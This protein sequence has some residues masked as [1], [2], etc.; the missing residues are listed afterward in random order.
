MA[1]EEPAGHWLIIVQWGT[2]GRAHV[3]DL[4]KHGVV[5]AADDAG[6]GVGPAVVTDPGGG[7]WERAG[8][9]VLDPEANGELRIALITAAAHCPRR[10]C[11]SRTS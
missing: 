11:P 8:A 9:L 2:A 4:C 5:S 10:R 1:R 3:S 7:R 6:G